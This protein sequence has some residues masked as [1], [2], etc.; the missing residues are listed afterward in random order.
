MMEKRKRRVTKTLNETQTSSAEQVIDV[1]SRHDPIGWRVRSNGFDFSCLEAKSL[2][3][4]DNMD[5]LKAK[6]AGI[7]DSIKVVDDFAASE[8]LLQCFWPTEY[9]KDVFG[10]QRSGFARKDLSSVATVN[11]ALQ[12]TKYSRLQ[13]QLL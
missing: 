5:R 4:I 10:F 6:I 13:W 7:S 3:V 12:L 1:Y 9:R 11:N 2:L 8:S